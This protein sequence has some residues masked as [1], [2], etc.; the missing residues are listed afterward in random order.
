MAPHQI[1]QLLADRQANAGAA[2][3]P[4]DAVVGLTEAIEQAGGQAL[5]EADTGIPHRHPQAGQRRRRRVRFDVHR[6]AHLALGRE[7]DGVG[8]E[9]GQNLLEAKPIAQEQAPRR[10]AQSQGEGHALLGGANPHQVGD[11]PNA[12]FQV[13]GPDVDGH[14]A[15]FDL[16][17][18]QH[19]GNQPLQK[20]AGGLDHAHH[21]ALMGGQGR[22]RQDA[23]DA[24]H[25]VER[26]ADLVR[27]VG[28]KVV[29]GLAGRFDRLAR[30]LGLAPGL[31]NL[32]LVLPAIRCREH[33]QP[34][35][36]QVALQVAD[37]LGVEEDRRP[38]AAGRDQIEGHL[39]H[40]PVH[41]QKRRDMGLEIDPPSHGKQA[42][43]GRRADHRL[44]RSPH[45]S[46]EIAIAGRQ[47]ITR[48]QHGQA[49]RRQVEQRVEIRD[50][51]GG[52][53]GRH[54]FP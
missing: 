6:Q 14:Q 22:C 11:A 15:G 25:R 20:Q 35:A 45:Q 46:A 9:V 21:V 47:D 5:I 31:E 53:G 16:R 28:Q 24:D 8:Q 44:G 3:P 18:I 34:N 52:R 32:G 10:L 54:V 4:G 7:L 13:E 49:A 50:S 30:R 23:G 1:H 39:I 36:A 26:R 38:S 19:V 2:E 33:R 43:K 48:P 29:L 51:R 40:P 41:L 12:G 37:Q 27:H 17:Q 42:G